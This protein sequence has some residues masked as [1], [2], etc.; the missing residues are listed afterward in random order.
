[1]PL[2]HFFSFLQTVQTVLHIT[3][4]NQGSYLLALKKETNSS[5]G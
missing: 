5:L 2:F 4:K 3:T 1:M